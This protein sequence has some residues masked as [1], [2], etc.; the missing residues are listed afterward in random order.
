MVPRPNDPSHLAD[1]ERVAKG[2]RL[3]V[4]EGLIPNAGHISVRPEGADWFWTPRHVHVGLEKMGPGDV[5]ACDMHGHAVESAWEASG[6]RFI[7]TEV[8]AR[9]PDVRSAGDRSARASGERSRGGSCRRTARDRPDA[10]G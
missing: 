4:R 10:T 2:V 9:R 3:L 7:Y 5:I 6:E 8:F 1:R